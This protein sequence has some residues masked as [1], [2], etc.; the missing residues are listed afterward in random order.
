[1]PL[2][3]PFP[4]S[5]IK[6]KKKKKKIIITIRLWTL[7]NYLENAKAKRKN[8]KEYSTFKDTN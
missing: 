3:Y 7:I 4:L 1:M 8:P 2:C 5:I 6:K